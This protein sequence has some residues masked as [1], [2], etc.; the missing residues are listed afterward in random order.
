M[1]TL[2]DKEILIRIQKGEIDYFTFIVKK[3]TQ[4]IFNYVLKKLGQR[5]EAEDVVQN[6]FL[7]FY[8]A[9]GRFD[10]DRPILPYLFQITKNEIKMYWRSKKKLLPLDEALVSYIE[11]DS[12]DQEVLLKKLEVLSGE[13]K[14]ALTLVSEGYSYKE[15][16]RQLQRP[17]NTV[18]TIIRR[19][20]LQIMKVREDE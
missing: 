14:K 17:L 1:G 4:Q 7:K 18:R 19:A 12:F 13:Q 8:K 16:S 9:I 10:V 5:D 6:S 15:I 11:E 3:Y 20:R 2:V